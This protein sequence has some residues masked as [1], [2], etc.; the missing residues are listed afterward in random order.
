MLTAKFALLA[1]AVC[2]AAF[3][4]SSSHAA[5]WNP[6]VPLC[7]VTPQGGKQV[8]LSTIAAASYD[9]Q[10]ASSSAGIINVTVHMGWCKVLSNASKCQNETGLSMMIESAGQCIVGFS[11]LSGSV[12]P[13]SNN[14]FTLT[15]W[16]SSSGFLATVNVNCD[17]S[18]PANTASLRGIISNSP[19][20]QMTMN[21]F[22]PAACGSL[23]SSSRRDRFFRKHQ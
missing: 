6:D 4:A 22:T 11:A 14:S 2:C 1:A 12:V 9:G 18:V 15:E 7:V 3:A 23:N 19:Y 21:F 20:G 10:L 8:N 13:V 17:K 16:S 5:P